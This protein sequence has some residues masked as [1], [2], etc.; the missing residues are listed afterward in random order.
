MPITMLTS[1]QVHTIRRHALRTNDR[2]LVEL[3][4]AALDQPTTFGGIVPL[5]CTEAR[6]ALS[7]LA[8]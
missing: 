1:K 5:T 2:G 8:R 6:T 4:D 3:C 7:K